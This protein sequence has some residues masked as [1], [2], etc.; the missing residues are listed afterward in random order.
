MV[1]ISDINVFNAQIYNLKLFLYMNLYSDTKLFDGYIDELNKI[2]NFIVHGNIA[3]REIHMS[4][5]KNKNSLSISEVLSNII[6]VLYNYINANIDTMIHGL[7]SYKIH[8][9][10]PE[11]LKHTIGLLPIGDGFIIKI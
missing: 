1:N 5:I 4:Y 10:T 3:N 2:D 11:L 9:I 8:S 7:R 6:S